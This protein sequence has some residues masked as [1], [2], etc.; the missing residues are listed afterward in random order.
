MPAAQTPRT[1]TRKLSGAAAAPLR[2][3]RCPAGPDSCPCPKRRCWAARPAE[4]CS[5]ASAEA[6]RVSLLTLRGRRHYWA[7]V[8]LAHSGRGRSHLSAVPDSKEAGGRR[9][10]P[11]IRLGAL[12]RTFAEA[13]IPDQTSSFPSSL[14]VPPLAPSEVGRVFLWSLG[15][16]ERT[17]L[18]EIEDFSRGGSS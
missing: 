12:L 11:P 2:S 8:S 18:Q 6:P 15:R 10:W 16:K 4:I 1:G 5:A 14:A 9:Y 3:E 7:P 13:S 17:T